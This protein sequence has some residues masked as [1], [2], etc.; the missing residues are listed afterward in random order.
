MEN[1]EQQISL[2]FCYHISAISLPFYPFMQK[3]PITLHLF[4]VISGMPGLPQPSLLFPLS[5]VNLI[6][7]SVIWLKLILAADPLQFLSTYFMSFSCYITYLCLV[8]AYQRFTS[9]PWI[10]MFFRLRNTPP[11]SI[12]VYRCCRCFARLKGCFDGL[13][14]DMQSEHKGMKLMFRPNSILV[15]TINI[16][17]TCRTCR[18][19]IE[20]MDM[21]VIRMNS[22]THATPSHLLSPSKTFAWLKLSERKN[23]AKLYLLHFLSVNTQIWYDDGYC[24][25]WF[26]L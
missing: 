8:V 4:R 15:H 7:L 14:T 3:I 9:V 23:F 18:L 22:C 21:K 10:I 2:S 6:F 25:I 5:Q 11:L 16:T 13:H 26:C 20:F 17:T 19:R 24:H 1:N 12:D